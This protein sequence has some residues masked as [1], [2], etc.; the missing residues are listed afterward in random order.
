MTIVVF[1]SIPVGILGQSMSSFFDIRC[2]SLRRLKGGEPIGFSPELEVEADLVEKFQSL[3][4]LIVSNDSPICIKKATEKIARY[5]FYELGFD[6]VPFRADEWTKV[7]Y[8]RHLNREGTRHETD[9]SLRCFVWYDTSNDSIGN[10]RLPVIGAA[11]FRGWI[12][13]KDQRRVWRLAWIWIHPYRRRKKMLSRAWPLFE[14]MF[15][16]FYV[17][18]PFSDG[19]DLFL[20]KRGWNQPNTKVV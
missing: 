16:L 15:G 14:R 4:I 11:C 5:F 6:F 20:Q 17:E 3:G 12:N 1:S 2:P 13:S 9:D 8:Y 19:M 10:L 7:R 18:S